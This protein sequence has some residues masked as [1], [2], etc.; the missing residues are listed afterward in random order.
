MFFQYVTFNQFLSFLYTPYTFSYSPSLYVIIYVIY[1]KLLE[2]FLQSSDINFILFIPFFYFILKYF[3]LIHLQI[4]WFLSTVMSNLLLILS[5][6][7]I[8][9]NIVV[10][11]LKNLMC[12]YTYIRFFLHLY[13]ICLVFLPPVS[14]T[15][16]L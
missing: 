7:F 15:Y 8:V 2:V 14:W 6:I 13:L 5:S 1:T 9:L 16:G 11:I 12:R 4:H 3:L 10:F